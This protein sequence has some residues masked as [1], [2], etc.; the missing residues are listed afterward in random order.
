MPKAAAKD[1]RKPRGQSLESFLETNLKDPG[2]RHH[3]ER[4]L[5][6]LRRPPQLEHLRHEL[7]HGAFLVHSLLEIVGRSGDVGRKRNRLFAKHPELRR[8]YARALEATWALYQA[9]GATGSNE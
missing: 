9:V 2:F 6:T 4:R 1:T 7:L 5:D 3:F 8:V